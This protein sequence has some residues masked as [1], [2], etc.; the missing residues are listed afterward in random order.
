MRSIILI[1]FSV[2]FIPNI[3]AQIYEVGAFLGGSN[4]IGDVGSTNYIAP[5]KPA[6]GLLIKW[7][8]SPRH[9]FRAS[10]IF[11]R[12]EGHDKDS[13]DPRRALRGYEFKNNIMEF[14][15]GMEFTFLDFD[16]YSMDPQ[17]TPYLYTGISTAR[18]KSFFY[19]NGTQSSQNINSWA[20]GIPMVFGFKTT[21]SRNF[22]LAAEIGVRYTFSDKIDGSDPGIITPNPHYIPSET[23]KYLLAPFGN[24]NS[25]DWYVFSGITLTYTFGQKPCY[26]YY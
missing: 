21:V 25:N 15:A 4:F 11:A 1:I 12:L 14:S 26:C 5:N 23:P 17:M 19:D 7:N 20:Y 6:A 3:H 16:L 8:R 9:S 18:H 13:N 22:I 24:K 2:C 10:A